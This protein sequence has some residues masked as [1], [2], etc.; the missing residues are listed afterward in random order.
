[1]IQFYRLRLTLILILTSKTSNKCWSRLHCRDCYYCCCHTHLRRSWGEIAMVHMLAN[2]ASH[3][4][5]TASLYRLQDPP[6]PTSSWIWCLCF[7]VFTTSTTD[8]LFIVPRR[9]NNNKTPNIDWAVFC[10]K[11]QNHRLPSYF[12]WMHNILWRINHQPCPRLNFICPMTYTIYL[13]I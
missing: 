12:I 6:Y 3:V 2:F 1:M 8:L 10:L 4:R 9:C 13:L 5:V 7:N 11:W